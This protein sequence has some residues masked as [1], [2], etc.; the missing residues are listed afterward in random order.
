MAEVPAESLAAQNGFQKD[1]LIQSINGQA[2][3]TLRDLFRLRDAAAGKPLTVGFVRAQ[4][5]QTRTL[6]VYEFAVSESV[7]TQDFLSLPLRKGDSVIR[8]VFASPETANEPVSTL[9]DG[10]LA[11]NYGPV[12]K[13]DVK[14][15]LYKADLGLAL[16]LGAVGSWSYNMGGNRGSQRYVLFVSAAKDDPGWSV[17]DGKRFTPLATVDSPCSSAFHATSVAMA[18]GKSLGTYR[19]LIWAVAPVTDIGENSAYQEF[20]VIPLGAFPIH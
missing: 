19:W 8:S 1:D 15:G 5:A 13:N 14:D 12:F 2:L 17:N 10:L 3:H 18:G 7:Q 6:V 11:A 20:Q 16:K 9:N 4:Q